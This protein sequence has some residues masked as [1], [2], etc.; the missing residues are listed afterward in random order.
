[1]Q[2]LDADAVTEDSYETIGQYF[3]LRNIIFN[4]VH[5]VILA[6]WQYIRRL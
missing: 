6:R 3:L 5:G 4:R 1:M 2:D